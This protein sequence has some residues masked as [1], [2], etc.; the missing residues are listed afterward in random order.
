MK[1]LLKRLNLNV[2]ENNKFWQSA[3]AKAKNEEE[4]YYHN[5]NI[6]CNFFN[7]GN[8]IILDDE[9][10]FGHEEHMVKCNIDYGFKLPEFQKAL[11]ILNNC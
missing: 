2:D 6:R 8:Y 7:I 3:F 1:E 4:I 5:I 9:E 11:Q 10:I